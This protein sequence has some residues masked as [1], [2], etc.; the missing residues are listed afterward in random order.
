MDMIILLPQ[1]WASILA[2]CIM[3]GTLIVAY[4]KR[5]M[6]TYALILA[7]MLV[8]IITLFYG[9]EVIS[10]IG[11]YAGQYSGWGGLGFRAIYLTPELFPQIY[12]LFTSMFIHGGFAHIFGNMLV[13]FFVGV[14]FEDRVGWKKFLIIYFLTGMAGALTHSVLN[15]N[16]VVPLIGASGAIFGIMGAFAYAYPRDEVLMP[17]PVGFFMII[18]RIKVLYAVFIFAAIETAVVLFDI[19]DYTAHYAHLGGLIAGV[20]LAMLLI[21]KRKRI[22]DNDV[23]SFQTTTYYDSYRPEK[24]IGF[25]YSSLKPLATTSELRNML[26]KVENETVPQVRDIWLEHF[27][28]K[29]RCPRCGEPLYHLNRRIW[30]EKCGFKIKY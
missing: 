24:P 17:I 16:S 18:R 2:I 13:L 1:H 21:K 12:T 25:D 7:N 4:V 20:V 26:K 15:L 14:P 6:M 11:G 23:S 30:C 27:V 3:I 22:D 29:T 19:K 9:A 5:W 10:G 28:E 8:F